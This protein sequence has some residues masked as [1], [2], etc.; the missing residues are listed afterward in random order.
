VKYDRIGFGLETSIR[1]YLQRFTRI[2]KDYRRDSKSTY[3]GI[4]YLLR[5]R[6]YELRYKVPGLIHVLGPA[7]KLFYVP[8][9][10]RVRSNQRL[11]GGPASCGDQRSCW[12]MKW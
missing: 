9:E 12:S 6:L 11:V 10:T 4:D 3:H 7:P 8:V 2:G 1:R 5:I